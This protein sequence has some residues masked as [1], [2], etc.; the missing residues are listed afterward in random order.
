MMAAPHRPTMTTSS[1]APP[2]GSARIVRP[3]ARLRGEVRLPGDKSISHRVAMFGAIGAG[4]TTAEN[5]LPGADCR[6]TLAILRALGVESTL[7]V[8]T[9]G[10]TRLTV[11]GVGLHGLR[12]PDDVLDAGNSGTSLRLFSGLLAG[13]PFFSVL[14]GDAS[15]RSRPAARVITPLR[16]MGGEIHAR[17]GDNLPPLV[18][19]GG[20]LHGISYATPVASAQVKSAV[21]LAGLYAAGATTVIEPA[22]SRDHTERLLRAMGAAISIDGLAVTVR[23]PAGELAPLDLRIPGDISAAAFWL[24]AA[25]T[26][27]DAEITLRD[28]GMNPTRTG[29]IDVLRQMGGDIE[30]LEER[31]Q[32]GEPVANLVARSSRLRGVEVR[33]AIIARLIDEVPALALAA[34]RAAGDTMIAD[35]AELRVKESDRIA[36][37]ARELRRFGVE[38]D[39][40]LDGMTIHGG[41]RLRGATCTPDGDHRLAMTVA[42]A[43][44]LAGGDSVVEDAGCVA[45]SYPTFWQ[46]LAALSGA[47]PPV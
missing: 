42:V 6:S 20:A 4:R 36:T 26:H 5:F 3:A 19:R 33:G 11:E 15:L 43:G 18:I 14:T 9:D 28:V 13:Q 24:V 35:A 45:V 34:A 38:V 37:T 22:A 46:D 10:V 25:L 7:D 23:P 1:A 12:E 44:L 8:A 16:Q 32:G 29:I 17:A 47:A 21:L 41:A 31:S 40:H 30:V 39:E 2:G 27:A